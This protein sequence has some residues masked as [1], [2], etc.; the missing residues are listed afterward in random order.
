MEGI[1][2]KAGDDFTESFALFLDQVVQTLLLYC[3]E[4]NMTLVHWRTKTSHGKRAGV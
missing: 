1:V 2:D 4:L 3:Y